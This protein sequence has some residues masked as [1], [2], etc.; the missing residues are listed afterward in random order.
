MTQIQGNCYFFFA[1]Y[2]ILQYNHIFTIYETKQ[3]SKHI[4]INI[5]N[6]QQ[7]PIQ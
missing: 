7:R 2:K 5:I 6:K 3:V 4:H 1:L